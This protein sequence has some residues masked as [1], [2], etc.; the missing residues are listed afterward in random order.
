MRIVSAVLTVLLVSTSLYADPLRC[1]L[2]EYK[3]TAGLS[4]GVAEETLTVTWDGDKDQEVR[5]R[6]AINGGTPTIR[7]L[8]VRRKGAP[9]ATVV[10]NAT[11]DY[12][13]VSGL[14][15]VTEQQLQPLR[16]LKIDITPAIVE[17]IKWDA[18]WDAP[19]NLE[20]GDTRETAIPPMK[21]VANQPGLPRTPEEIKRATAAYQAQ[22][23]D[24]KST[25][26]RLEIT[27]PGVQ[28]GV[29]TG[30]LQYTIF[31]GT[32]LIKQEV[33]AQ[34]NE[35]S[36]AYKYDAGLKGI[37]VQPTSRIVWRDTANNWQDYRFGA[38]INEAPV[39]LRASNRLV[40]AE[41]PGG[42]I[43]AFP[44]PHNF[45]WSRETAF[46]LGYTWYRKDN[47]TSFSFGVKQAEAEAAPA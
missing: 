25:G 45:F 31:K 46:N 40:V 36:V 32:N 14:R 28:L 15:R 29:F 9:W 37:A 11:P 19:L 44:P 2:A 3:A 12:R 7:D 30:R 18:F 38:A 35:P 26:A 8:A 24:V 27:F 13:V 16:Q 22:G 41:G 21:G 23:C 47:P 42:S 34:T 20:I 17:R 1:N 43:A 10:S 33:V 6:L 4:A 39:T 5:L